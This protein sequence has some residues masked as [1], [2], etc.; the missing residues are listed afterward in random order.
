VWRLLLILGGF[1]ACAQSPVAD[2]EL[3]WRWIETD[4]PEVFDLSAHQVKT[5][6]F[7]L[8]LAAPAPPSEIRRNGTEMAQNGVSAIEEPVSLNASDVREIVVQ[9]EHPGASYLKL[10]LCWAPPNQGF[11]DQRTLQV[12]DRIPRNRSS[13]E[14]RFSV[15]SH[16]EWRGDVARLGVRAAAA[17]ATRIREI[18]GYSSRV[19]SKGLPEILDRPWKIDVGSDVRNG[20]VTVPGTALRSR[21]TVPPRG[22]EL[23]LSFAHLERSRMPVRYSVAVT[24]HGRREQ[25]FSRTLHPDE[26][27]T[28]A[29][30]PV[31]VDLAPWAGEDVEL[32][33]ETSTESAGQEL[34]GLPA[35]A[36]PEIIATATR[37]PR[38][39]VVLISIDTLRADRMSLYGHDRPTTPNLA[40]WASRRGTVF[41]NVVAAA[42]WTLPSHTSM[43]SGVGALRHGVNY[44]SP[45]PGSLKLLS[46]YLREAGYA[47]LAVTGG[48]WVHPA[49]HLGQG[50]DRFRYWSGTDPDTGAPINGAD[51]E[52]SVILESATALLREHAHEPFFLFLHTYDIHYRARRREP[53]FTQFSDLDFTGRMF[54][55]TAASTAEN[56]YKRAKYRVLRTA[57][58][59]IPL[60]QSLSALP[61]DIYDSR[62]AYLDSQLPVLFDELDALGLSDRTLVIFTSDHGELLGEHG[63]YGHVYLHDEN[64]MIPLI[65]GLP[66]GSRGHPIIDAQVRSIDIVPTVLDLLGIQSEPEV[67]GDSLAA[68]MRRGQED[69]RRP[70]ASYVPSSNYGMSLRIGNRAK[71]ILNNAAWAPVAGDTEY[72]RIDLDP[73]ESQ[74]L[75]D[76]PELSTLRRELAHAYS[77]ATPG[78]RLELD[79]PSSDEFAL[80]IRNVVEQNNLKAVDLVRDRV[81]WRGGGKAEI[82]VPSG[83]AFTL[84]LENAHTTSLPLEITAGGDDP[85]DERRRA[86]VDLTRD[87]QARLTLEWTG[88]EWLRSEGGIDQRLPSISLRWAGT[89]FLEPSAEAAVGDEL[90]AR[91]RA[92]GYTE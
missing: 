52:L 59:E 12:A 85:S 37:R 19:D 72:Y 54:W 51:H 50:F 9:V 82:T 6:S 35:W 83:A 30:T 41:R 90:R 92:L 69:R 18:A 44:S 80:T 7:R 64:L 79:N 8:R 77:E 45:A 75:S 43:L 46:E 3:V 57:D 38:T 2:R 11:T 62:I 81:H 20:F 70:A 33:L 56:G 17:A 23:R 36:N 49:Y 34:L 91:L 39:N 4:R 1:C 28:T 61:A 74:N 5:E 55:R 24:H 84:I 63:V 53:F 32:T 73:T 71:L 10:R 86:V 15:A 42:P 76:A 25:V 40:A 78:V 16:P 14:H 29:W 27:P 13:S 21:C 60:P 88:T 67:E 87:V 22:G 48:G 31:Q 26:T 66:G 47:T 68:L 89:K 65:V 58:G